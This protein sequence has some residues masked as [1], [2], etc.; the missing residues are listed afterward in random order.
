MVFTCHFVMSECWILSEIQT[1][2]DNSFHLKTKI[3]LKS[4]T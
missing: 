4:I 3:V 2:L 1:V